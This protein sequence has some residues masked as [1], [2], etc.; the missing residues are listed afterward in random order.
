MLARNDGRVGEGGGGD[1]ATG[2]H[3]GG[4]AQSAEC[5]FQGT[6]EIRIRREENVCLPLP[7]PSQRSHDRNPK[8]GFQRSPPRPS[9]STR[10]RFGAK[11]MLRFEV[12]GT[13]RTPR[14]R[15]EIDHLMT[16]EWPEGG[17]FSAETLG[18]SPVID[19]CRFL[20]WIHL[21][22]TRSRPGMKLV[23]SA[24]RSVLRTPRSNAHDPFG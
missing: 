9:S 24:Q 20:T 2:A 14:S 22:R 10:T 4:L 17:R 21:P 19:V 6:I 1:R 16:G 23:A 12:G 5:E 13:S 8:I 7:N 18:N 11:E 15:S 3:R